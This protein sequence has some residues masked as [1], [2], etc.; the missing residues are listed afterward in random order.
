MKTP[1]GPEGLDRTDNLT[2]F[3]YNVKTVHHKT[4][5]SREQFWMGY[6]ANHALERADANGL[7]SPV[8]DQV[9]AKW[10]TTE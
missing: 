1:N 3:C 6:D 8:P 9:T 2:W 4:G 7:F 5:E 10:I